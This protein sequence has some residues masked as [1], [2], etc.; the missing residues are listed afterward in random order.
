MRFTFGILAF[1]VL[2][3]AGED[4]LLAQRDEVTISGTI[5]TADNTPVAG[6]IL[7]RLE[8]SSPAIRQQFALGG[9][10]E[11]ARVPPGHYRVVV[12]AP[13]YRDVYV[14]AFAP[15]ERFISIILQERITPTVNGGTVSVFDLQVPKAARR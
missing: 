14:I 7:V 13:G 11:F 15:M 3:L 10:F 1:A 5:R 4:R 6:P 8:A 9:R 2:S 12:Q